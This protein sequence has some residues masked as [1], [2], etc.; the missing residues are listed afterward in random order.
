VSVVVAFVF[1]GVVVAA[2]ALLRDRHSPARTRP[3]V[4]A[5]VRPSPTSS[6]GP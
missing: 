5:T 1:V 2:G 4:A 3:P 6:T